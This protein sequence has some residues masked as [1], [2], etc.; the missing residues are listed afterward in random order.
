MIPLEDIKEQIVNCKIGS[1]LSHK[2]EVT[3]LP[4]ILLDNEKINILFEAKSQ[5][6]E[7]HLICGLF[8]GTDDRLIFLKSSKYEILV[9]EQFLYDD[10]IK[11]KAKQRSNLISKLMRY[12]QI[13]IET[14]D[15][16]QKHVFLASGYEF[17]TDDLETI[18]SFLNKTLELYR[19]N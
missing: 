6:A 18:V 11:I 12:P 7:P 15:E 3:F 13:I 9:F 5:N 4:D 1:D 2:K 19:D 16:S 14:N 10:I 17:F 8:I